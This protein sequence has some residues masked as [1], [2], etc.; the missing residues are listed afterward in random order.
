MMIGAWMFKGGLMGL[1][2]KVP[3]RVRL[4]LIC[5]TLCKE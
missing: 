3:Q 5:A 1:Q 4:K 2:I